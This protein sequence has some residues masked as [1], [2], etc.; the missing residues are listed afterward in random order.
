MARILVVDDDNAVRTLIADILKVAKY[1][2]DTAATVKTALPLFESNYYNLL[3]ADLMLPDGSGI[4]VAEEAQRRGTP[5][6]ILTAYAHRFRKA[7]LARFGLMLKPVRPPE[8]LD[9]VE[10][11]LRP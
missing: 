6:I 9:A 5:A 3:L 7:D 10:K 4:Q 8:L 1:E 2:I 11:A